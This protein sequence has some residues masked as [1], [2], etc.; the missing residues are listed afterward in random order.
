M[1]CGIAIGDGRLADDVVAGGR[2]VSGDRAEADFSGIGGVTVRVRGDGTAGSAGCATEE[3][4]ETQG[5]LL[6]QRYLGKCCCDGVP[7]PIDTPR[8]SNMNAAGHST[9]C[10]PEYREP[11]DNCCLLRASSLELATRTVDNSIATLGRTAP[12][13]TIRGVLLFSRPFI[14]VRKNYLTRRADDW[15]LTSQRGRSLLVAHGVAAGRAAIF[16]GVV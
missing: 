11:A 16:R 9:R 15:G 1:A 4:R 6:A 2:P 8:G 7:V 10:R 3:L 14:P 13:N 12:G 5:S